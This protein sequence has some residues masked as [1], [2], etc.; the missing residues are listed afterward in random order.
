MDRRIRV[1]L[2]FL[3]LLVALVATMGCK[4][5]VS[6]PSTATAPPASMPAPTASITASPN[7]VTAGQQIVLTWKTTNATSVKIDGIGDVS[8]SGAKNVVSWAS[9]TYHLV[10]HGAAGTADASVRVTVSAPLPVTA[11]NTNSEEDFKAHVKDIF[12]NYDKF[13]VR[14]DAQAPLSND[15]SYLTAHPDLKIVIGG[16]CDER[17]SDEYNLGLGQNRA[18][19]I[20]KALVGAGVTAARIRVISYGKEKPFC[21]DPT[22]AC[23]QSN[24]RAGFTMD[25]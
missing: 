19:T 17:G 3:L 13:D 2:A 16:Y 5:K 25:H 15:A 8:S 6:P 21:S 11:S 12:F 24:R 7:D 9:T 10:A 23:W 4:K 18:E 20:K 14:T 1:K 22:E